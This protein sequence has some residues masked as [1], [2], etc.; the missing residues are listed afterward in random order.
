MTGEIGDIRRALLK[1][2]DGTLVDTMKLLAKDDYCSP[3]IL[4]DLAKTPM[5]AR[6][7]FMKNHR[8][9]MALLGSYRP[10]FD[11]FRV[12]LRTGNLT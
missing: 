8:S 7:R 5:Q 2:S 6:L 12:N 11:A 3:T 10:L 1:T 4:Q 9:L